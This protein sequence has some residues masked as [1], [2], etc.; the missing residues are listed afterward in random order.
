MFCLRSWLPL[1]FIPT[2]A[3]PLFILSFITLT[4]LLHRPCHYCS[5]LLLILFLSSCHWSDRCFFDFKGDWFSPRFST[6]TSLPATTLPSDEDPTSGLAEYVVEAVNTT[7]TTLAGAAINEAKRRLSSSGRT[8]GNVQ[9]EWTGMGLEWFRSLLG[10]R[11]WTIPCVDVKLPHSQHPD[12]F[13]NPPPPVTMAQFPD[14]PPELVL[15]IAENLATEDLNHLLRTCRPSARLLTPLLYDRLFANNIPDDDD[16]DRPDAIE[17]KDYSKFIGS[18]EY[19]DSEFVSSYLLNLSEK[20][21]N[22]TIGPNLTGKLHCRSLLHAAIDTTNVKAVDILLQRGSRFESNSLSP[23]IPTPLAWAAICGSAPIL[24][25][26][27]NAGADPLYLYGDD[28]GYAILY[29]AAENDDPEIMD[30]ALKTVKSAG[31]HV[32][33]N[34]LQ[35]YVLLCGASGSC[36]YPSVVKYLLELGVNPIGD[37][38]EWCPLKHAV[39]DKQMEVCKILIEAIEG[40]FDGEAASRWKTVGL[41]HAVEATDPGTMQ[42]FLDSGADPLAVYEG[43]MAL[44]LALGSGVVEA[45]TVILDTCPEL[46]SCPQAQESFEEYMELNRTVALWGIIEVITMGKLSLDLSFHPNLAPRE[47]IVHHLLRLGPRI[48]HVSDLKTLVDMGA[49]VSKPDSNGYTPLHVAV[50]LD[51]NKGADPDDFLVTDVILEAASSKLLDLVN[52]VDAQG[53]TALHYVSMAPDLIKSLVKHGANIEAR[54]TSGKTTLCLAARDGAGPE[55]I[56][57]YLSLG[58]DRRAVDNDG[59]PPAHYSVLYGP[60]IWI[61]D[62][63]IDGKGRWHENCEFCGDA[64]LVAG[65]H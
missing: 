31:A 38:D 20:D 46:Q 4:Y 56:A 3:S 58:A 6:P 11:E 39:R 32:D 34:G 26:L 57:S 14:L 65:V 23:V 9:S 61:W 29:G 62:Q 7:A 1:L 18:I 47:T 60:G 35:G 30:L 64:G 59:K 21:A 45:A 17:Y 25:L 51:D 36:G 40:K 22:R 2:N 28:Y 13:S 16:E 5:V 19:W 27:L 41:I 37:G 33:L 48:I 52:A 53:N 42:L 44:D 54:N 55:V 43:K 63:F 15:L 10:R 49:D 24:R 12:I 8:P 50:Y